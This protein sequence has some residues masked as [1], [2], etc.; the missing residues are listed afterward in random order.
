M[1]GISVAIA[2]PIE[3]VC[4]ED[5]RLSV[6]DLIRDHSTA[7]AEV[8]GELETDPLFDANKHDDLWIL[9]FI[10]SH[11]KKTKS[12]VKAA[13][14]TLGFRA[15][16]RLDNLDIRDTPPHKVPEGRVKEYYDVRCFKNRC[17]VM[18]PDKQ[19]GAISYVDLGG[20]IPG[21]SQKVEYDTWEQ[22]YIYTSE[23]THQWLD[24]VTRT[25]G[26]LTKSIRIIDM[27]TASMAFFDRHDMKYD[28]TVMEKMEDCYPQLLES[29]SAC[30]TP[31]W[32][33]IIWALGRKIMPKRVVEK[34]DIINPKQNQA[35]R[36]RLHKYIS[37]ENLPVEYGGVNDS[38][39]S[40]KW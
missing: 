6:L 27:K 22:G 14:Y 31:S 38:P 34:F 16:H 17:I 10:L 26:R 13:K 39:Y 40:G 4:P 7:I 29:I 3:P 5:V 18:V 8:R 23:W 11:K 35:E 36:D 24:F 32:I 20:H 33:H 28:S 25:T 21:C 12:A 9:R 19:R 37:E 15:Q 1:K 2:A 30:N